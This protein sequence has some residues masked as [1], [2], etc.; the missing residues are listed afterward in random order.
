MSS[1]RLSKR[2]AL[3]DASRGV[4]ARGVTWALGGLL[5]HNLAVVTGAKTKSAGR[6][7]GALIFL[8]LDNPFMRLCTNGVLEQAQRSNSVWVSQV[9][10]AQSSKLAFVL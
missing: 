3:Y 9:P 4:R 10:L 7:L 6:H 1:S 5:F 2:T 8:Q